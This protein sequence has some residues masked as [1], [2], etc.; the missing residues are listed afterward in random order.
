MNSYLIIIAALGLIVTSCSDDKKSKTNAEEVVPKEII[1]E[2]IPEA[3]TE[4]TPVIEVPE[5]TPIEVEIKEGEVDENT[6]N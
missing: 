4:E 5:E 2:V 6:D 1:E 3:V